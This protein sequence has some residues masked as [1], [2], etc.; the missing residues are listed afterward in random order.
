MTGEAVRRKSCSVSASGEMWPL[1]VCVCVCV[2]VKSG[3]WV[4]STLVNICTTVLITINF[5]F[6]R[7]SYLCVCDSYSN[8]HS[9]VGICNGGAVFSVRYELSSCPS[10]PWISGLRGLTS[11]GRWRLP[12][13]QKDTDVSV[14]HTA[15]IPN[16]STLKMDVG[17]LS[18]IRVPVYQSTWRHTSEV[19]HTSR[20][21]WNPNLQ[22][23]YSGMLRRVDS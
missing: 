20:P 18:E 14:N 7:R 12:V 23:R 4:D 6:C 11:S 21:D 17:C 3:R 9:H 8:Q 15:S 13:R 19:G 10:C 5:E 1:C 2:R 16:F 22:L